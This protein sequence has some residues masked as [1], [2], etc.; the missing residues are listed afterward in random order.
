MAKILKIPTYKD[1]KGILSVVERFIKFKIRRVYFLYNF[2]KKNRG[3]HKHKKNRQFLVCLSGKVQLKVINKNINKLYNLS[4]PTVGVL[5][6]PQDWHEIIPI[7]KNSIVLVLA[8]EFFN[9]KDYFNE[10]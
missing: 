7:K 2:K 1:K 10:I 6:E 8:S 9:K 4:K 3:K 5:L